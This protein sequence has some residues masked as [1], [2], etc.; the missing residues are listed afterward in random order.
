M[1]ANKIDW[2]EIQEL[3]DEAREE[4]HPVACLIQKL[5]LE[6]VLA[7]EYVYTNEEFLYISI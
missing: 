4:S 1:I 3:I 6:I 5:K 7:L 2:N